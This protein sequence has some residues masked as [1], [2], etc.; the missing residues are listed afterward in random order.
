MD[1]LSKKSPIIPPSDPAVQRH[2]RDQAYRNYQDL[3]GLNSN[4]DSVDDRVTTLEGKYL[5]SA[6]TKTIGSGGDFANFKQ[7]IAWKR[8]YHFPEGAQVIFQLCSDVNITTQADY[9]WTYDIDPRFTTYAALLVQQS[10]GYVVLDMNSYD[11]SAG[12]GADA[13]NMLVAKYGGRLRVYNSSTEY[14]SRI[15][16]NY[17]YKGSGVFAEF[18]SHISADDNS[19][20]YIG[21]DGGE[22]GNGIL[23]RFDSSIS[24][25]ALDAYDP[26]KKVYYC[27][28]GV[29]CQYQSVVS[30]PYIKCFGR[31]KTSTT[32][33]YAGLYVRHNSFI[34]A[35][36]SYMNTFYIAA[37]TQTQAYVEAPSSTFYNCYYGFYAANMGLSFGNNMVFSSVTDT[38]C[39]NANTI[40]NG[41]SINIQ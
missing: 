7:A 9:T 38:H 31:S 1:L 2:L 3:S 14:V 11:I 30:C 27:R 25:S 26:T 36:G 16:S 22:F 21:K 13:V 12:N 37:T 20:I 29:L 23:A 4:M 28:Q 33:T 19:Y 39:P 41:N 32:Y 15:Y 10:D 5:S 40:G 17:R 6:V 8:Q 18:N 34:Y 24:F 35:Q